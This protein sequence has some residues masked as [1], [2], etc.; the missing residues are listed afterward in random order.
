ML[1]SIRMS[2]NMADGSP[3]KHLFTEFCY[4][5][6]NLLFGKLVSVKVN[7]FSNTSTV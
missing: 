2:T 7:T 3:Q 6:V 5:S 4:K 1:V